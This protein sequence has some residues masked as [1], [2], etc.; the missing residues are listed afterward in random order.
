M[1]GWLNG[2]DLILMFQSA[3]G[4][5]LD[6]IAIGASFLGT[7]AFFLV[8]VPIYYWCAN[9]REGVRLA[10]VFLLSIYFNSV[11]KEIFQTPRPDPELVRVLYISSGNGFSFPSGHAQNALVFWGWLARQ[12]T[13]RRLWPVLAGLVLA[14]SLSRIYLGL[15][16][17]V[18]VAG[19]WILG[20]GLLGGLAILDRRISK[21]P[22]V[23]EGHILPW[24]GVVL[25]PV[26]FMLRTHPVQAMISGAMLGFCLGYL[27]ESRW[28]QFSP[29][30]TR[31]H[32]V[33]KALAGWVIGALVSI[34]LRAHLP[35]GDG[36]VAL[37]YA[38]LGLWVS[39]GLPLLYQWV[40]Q[41]REVRLACE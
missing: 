6:W 32:Q 35:S 23:W 4:A 29:Q 20:A 33:A 9:K 39:L 8:F 37:Q 30:T 21:R 7:E 19:G 13:W 17:P 2:Y 28:V 22:K 12:P 5:V 25:P 26:F 11:L 41:R 31:G 36:F 38:V 14:I 15:H 3:H 40:S 16:F 24:A 18:D 27:V 34:A 1:W 10:L